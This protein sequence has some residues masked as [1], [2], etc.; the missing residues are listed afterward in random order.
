MWLAPETVRSTLSTWA[1][2]SNRGAVSPAKMQD[3][4]LLYSASFS[5]ET[6]AGVR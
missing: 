1:N 2:H 3:F 5:K 6:S 4:A